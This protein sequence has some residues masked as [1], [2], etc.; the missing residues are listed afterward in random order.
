MAFSICKPDIGVCK[1]IK[2]ECRRFNR[3][4]RR[5]HALHLP[6]SE[7]LIMARREKR[8]EKWGRGNMYLERIGFPRL[9]L[10]SRRYIE[11]NRKRGEREKGSCESGYRFVTDKFDRLT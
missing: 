9:L 1:N 6:N 2:M 10:S 4:Q 3:T 11:K 5:S 8:D 7:L